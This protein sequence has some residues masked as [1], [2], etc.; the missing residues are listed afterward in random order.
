MPTVLRRQHRRTGIG[1]VNRSTARRRAFEFPDVKRATSNLAGEGGGSRRRSSRHV[2]A[3]VARRNGNRARWT[4]DRQPPV[5]RRTR[6]LSEEAS[7]PPAR[8]GARDGGRTAGPRATIIRGR[9]RR[10][11]RARAAGPSRGPHSITASHIKK[12]R[13]H[14]LRCIAFK[15]GA[16]VC[17][18][19]AYY[20]AITSLEQVALIASCYIKATRLH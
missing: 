19:M 10:R 12:T 17:V 16:W 13:S 6:R 3:I 4:H 15:R 9:D 8:R 7:P 11:A 14:S 2:V 5:A 20:D 18:F 1:T